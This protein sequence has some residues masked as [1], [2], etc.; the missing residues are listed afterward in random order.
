MN[1]CHSIVYAGDTAQKMRPLLKSINVPYTICAHDMH[2]NIM[3]TTNYA[4]LNDSLKKKIIRGTLLKFFLSFHM[5]F[6]T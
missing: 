5:H 4:C 2:T 6:T 3:L 1:F